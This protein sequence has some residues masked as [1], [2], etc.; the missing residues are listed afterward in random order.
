M[1]C[2]IE[3]MA[4]AS[5]LLLAVVVSAVVAA[6][7]ADVTKNLDMATELRATGAGEPQKRS[8][9]SFYSCLHHA[10]STEDCMHLRPLELDQDFDDSEDED[11]EYSKYELGETAGV[12]R[13]G[14]LGGGGSV[15]SAGMAAAGGKEEDEW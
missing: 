11:D 7:E 10:E 12:G 5:H 1:G 4:S 9:A 6:R 2:E 3:I 15:S 13:G 8:L 14:F